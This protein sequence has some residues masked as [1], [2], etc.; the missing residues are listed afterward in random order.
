[1]HFYVIITKHSSLTKLQNKMHRK[2]KLILT[3]LL[4]LSQNCFLKPKNKHFL[5]TTN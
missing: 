4:K 5:S 2:K 1:M 3:A